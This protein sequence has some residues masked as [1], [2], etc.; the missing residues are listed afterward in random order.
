MPYIPHSQDEINEM[1]QAIGVKSIGDLFQS[2]PADLRL[3]K[4]LNLPP[5]MSE[6]ELTRHMKTLADKNIGADK[7][8][9][10]LGAGCYNHF[11]P[12]VVNH[13][14][15]RS[16]FYTSYTPYQPEAS[17]GNLTAFFEYQTM[18]CELTGMEVANASVYDAS[19][20]LAE[21]ILMSLSSTNKKKVVISNT[22]HPEYREV[23]KTY[24]KDIDSQIVEVGYGKNG[25]TDL[26]ALEEAIT[27]D[28]SCVAI[29]SPNFFGIIEECEEISALAHKNNALLVAIV[30]PIS[31]G[32]L[33]APGEYDADIV[34]GEGQSLGN[35][36]YFGG[37]FL[38]I[39]AA[40]MKYVRKMPG[41]LVGETKDHDGK[42]G[43]VLTLSTREQHI[44]REKATS[45]ICSNEALLALRAGIYLAS[46]GKKGIK[47][48]A[49]LCAHKAH[50][51]AEKIGTEKGYKPVFEGP[52]FNEFA[53]KC[54]I[55]PAELNKKLIKQGIIGGLDLGRFYPE[56]KGS[57]LF[58]ATEVNTKF[59]IDRLAEA[60]KA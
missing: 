53:M 4:L 27:P 46:V 44:R 45:N 35:E 54:P 28:T 31:L 20:G 50:Y 25:Q 15:G 55:K 11:I 58:C 34:V 12:A 39:F 22:V 6:L 19:T 38:G 36:M 13:L 29:Q 42:R 10:F 41:R 14:A 16:E 57:I 60:I 52:F 23:L 8:I 24:L 30:K 37:P 21:A 17:Q 43:F 49:T 7:Y 48:V 26:A 59:D 2:I 9:S 33:K 3:K 47:D 1:L 51:A 18:I 5:A 40:K 32:I 56:L